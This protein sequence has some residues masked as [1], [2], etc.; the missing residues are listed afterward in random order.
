MRALAPALI[1]CAIDYVEMQFRINNVKY[2][3]DAFKTANIVVF[4]VFL[5]ALAVDIFK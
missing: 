5:I 2:D 3:E 1:L 4:C